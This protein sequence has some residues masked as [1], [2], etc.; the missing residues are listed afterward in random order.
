MGRTRK[1]IL[2]ILS[3]LSG[4]GIVISAICIWLQNKLNTAV[5]V[6][7][8]SDGPTSIFIAG[9]ARDFTVVYMAAILL[10]LVTALTFW[11]IGGIPIWDR[12]EVFFTMDMGEFAREERILS[13]HKIR[14][15]SKIVRH[16]TRNNQMLGRIGEN[17]NCNAT[18]AVYTEKKNAEEAKY[19]LSQ[20]MGRQE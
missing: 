2:W 3:V 10:I 1:I 15:R 14:Y 13:G 16:T 17:E 7:G 18:Y 11:L 20:E 4:V 9:S 19:H 5:S 8:R 12:T 6:I